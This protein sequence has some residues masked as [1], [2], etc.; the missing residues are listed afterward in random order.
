MEYPAPRSGPGGLTARRAGRLAAWCCGALVLAFVSP[1]MA[2]TPTLSAVT[3]EEWARPRR[4]ETVAGMPALQ[5]AV[6]Q[7]QQRPS[8]RLVLFYAGGDDGNLWAEEIRA[9]LVALG[10][11]GARI[12]LRSGLDGPDRVELIVEGGGAAR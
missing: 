11:P 12:E 2:E 3:A 8:A 4:G 1:S 7:L 6:R 10:V 5:Q 9:W